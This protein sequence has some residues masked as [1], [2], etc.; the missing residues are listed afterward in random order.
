MLPLPLFGT[1]PLQLPELLQ[2]PVGGPT[3]S[4]LIVPGGRIGARATPAPRLPARLF[5]VL[6]PARLMNAALGAIESPSFTGV[7]ASLA[8]RAAANRLS[9]QSGGSVR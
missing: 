8:R 1:P 4:S 2:T 5:I 6:A 3:Q 7:L 9:S